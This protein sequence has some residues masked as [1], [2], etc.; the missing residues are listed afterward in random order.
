MQRRGILAAAAT[1]TWALLARLTS[2]PVT[3]QAANPVLLGTNNAATTPTTITNAGGT[4]LSGSS[5]SSL[6]VLGIST[7]NVGVQGQSGSGVGLFGSSGSSVGLMG[8]SQTNVG[9]QGQSGS[10]IGLFGF[11]DSGIGLFGQSTTGLA[12][13]FGGNVFVTGSLSVQ[14][15]KS[16][17]VPHPDGSHRRLFCL[18]SPES[19]FEDFGRGQLNAGRARI[20]LDSDFAAT[21]H[22]DD[23]DVFPVPTGDCNGLYVA[24]KRPGSF[25]VCELR[26]GASNV[27]FSYRVVAKRRDVP[28][29]RMP[30]AVVPPPHTPL[31][32]RTLI[33]D[34][35]P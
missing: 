25:E 14:G 35:N 10:S 15:I 33:R 18:E 16:A 20:A 7:A 28:R 9:L 30:R 13:Q 3:A 32:A 26:G 21:V 27:T 8:Y 22:S 17:V 24:D 34:A 6:G 12:G 31:D 4:A 29:E 1:M 11:S 23:Y 19:Y 2:S 5:M